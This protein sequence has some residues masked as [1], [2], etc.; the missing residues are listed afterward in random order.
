M[1][2]RA[3]DRADKGDVF[4]WIRTAFETIGFARVSTSA[5][6]ARRL[7][8]LRDVDS[9][10]MNRERAIAEAKA[11]AL[12]RVREGYRPPAPRSTIPVGGADLYAKLS[13]GVHLLLRGG[14]I[15]DHDALVARKLAWVLAGGDM[16]HAT[17][18]SEQY[19]LDLEREAFLSLCGESRTLAKI[20]DRLRR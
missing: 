15:T 1:L 16:P 20:S 5:D 6:D 10:T 2:I 4:P 9:V 17:T 8:Y 19:L 12:N 18:V 13:L 7:G 14:R 11:E 3:I